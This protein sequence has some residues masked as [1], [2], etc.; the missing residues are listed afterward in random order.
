MTSLCFP[1]TSLQN[2]GELDTP[3]QWA[4]QIVDTQLLRLGQFVIISVPGEFTTMSGR[5]M[6]DA[7][8][9]SL[10]K[11]GMPANT[12]VVLA[13][14]TNEYADYITTNEEYQVDTLMI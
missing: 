14:L 11:S 4:P 8:Q 5:R 1:F 3:Y 6:R 12:T 9:A 13:G 2:I 10:L 7:V